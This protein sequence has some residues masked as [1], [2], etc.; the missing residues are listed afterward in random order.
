MKASL[1]QPFIWPWM[2]N[3][4]KR[5]LFL[6]PPVIANDGHEWFHVLILGKL[7]K[8]LAKCKQKGLQ[9]SG[10]STITQN[11]LKFL[12]NLEG[13]IAFRVVSICTTIFHN[14]PSADGAPHI[15]GIVLTP[16]PIPPLGP[17]LESLKGQRLP[18]HTIEEGFLSTVQGQLILWDL[19][20]T[21]TE[22]VSVF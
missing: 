18:Y 4:I 22:H 14:S 9:N 11:L 15:K 12:V 20:E 21:D 10:Q 17:D 1:G 6:L 16:G 7:K 2:I 13:L 19:I 5:Q 3:I 8:K